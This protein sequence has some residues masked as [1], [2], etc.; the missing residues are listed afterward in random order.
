MNK[1]KVGY[2]LIVLIVTLLVFTS[3]FIAYTLT[4]NGCDVSLAILI[5][6]V[7]GVFGGYIDEK[8]RKITSID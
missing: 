4:T 7:L 5:A 6:S 1:E 8:I 3:G 2:A